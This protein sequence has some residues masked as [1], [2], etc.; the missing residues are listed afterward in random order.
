VREGREEV[1]RAAEEVRR[2]AED[3]RKEAAWLRAEVEPKAVRRQR[4]IANEM[5]R[6][7][8][9]DGRAPPDGE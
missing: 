5:R 6:T 3:G 9:Q 4:E 1:R 7:A 8:R 2:L